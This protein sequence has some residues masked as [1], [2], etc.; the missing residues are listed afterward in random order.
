MLEGKDYH[1]LYRKFPFVAV[2][3]DQSTRHEWT[4]LWTMVHIRYGEIMCDSTRAEGH[5]AWTVKA[6]QMLAEGVRVF[7]RLVVLTFGEHCNSDLYTLRYHSTHHTVEDVR[8]IET[9]SVL[10]SISDELVNVHIKHCY[11]K[12]LKR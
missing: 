11:R 7:K 10:D 1:A 8:K 5:R 2:I 3:I 6:L 9:L 12:T 4:A